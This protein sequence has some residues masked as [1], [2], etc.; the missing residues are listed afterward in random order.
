M[1][2]PLKLFLSIIVL[3][4]LQVSLLPASLE[5][6]FK[7]NLMIIFVCYLA[8]RGGNSLAGAVIAYLIGLL[9]GSFSGFYFGLSGISFLLIYLLLN[10]VSDQLYTESIPLI[11]T[12]VFVATLVDALITLFLVALFSSES[13]IYLTILRNMIPHAVMTALFTWLF[14]SAEHLL[15]KRLAV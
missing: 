12:A 7:P 11:T 8:L 3:L 9:H 1:L 14:F 2:K 15:G 10:K 13:A 5:D 6:P 4:M